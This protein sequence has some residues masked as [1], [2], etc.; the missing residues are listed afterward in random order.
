M[1]HARKV[2]ENDRKWADADEELEVRPTLDTASLVSN[3]QTLIA[4]LV[5]YN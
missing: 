1:A 3:N 4:S 2:T 5:S